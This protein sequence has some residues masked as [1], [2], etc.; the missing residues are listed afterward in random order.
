MIESN[1]FKITKSQKKSI[2]IR[3]NKKFKKQALGQITFKK[4][5]NRIT[6]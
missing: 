3:V 2:F 5:N 4:T 6:Y 1:F